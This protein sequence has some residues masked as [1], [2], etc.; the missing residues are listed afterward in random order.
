MLLDWPAWQLSVADSSQ[1]REQMLEWNGER[2]PDRYTKAL[3]N[4]WY[5]E[6]RK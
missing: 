6:L 1:I 4:R 2:M 3:V 5:D